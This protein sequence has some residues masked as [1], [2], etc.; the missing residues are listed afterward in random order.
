MAIYT[1][2]GSSSHY[3]PHKRKL[4]QKI[5]PGCPKREMANERPTYRKQGR[6]QNKTW[7]LSL[8]SSTWQLVHTNIHESTW[9]VEDLSLSGLCNRGTD[10]RKHQHTPG[11]LLTLH[12][13]VHPARSK[14]S[15]S[16]GATPPIEA[17]HLKRLFCHQGLT[18]KEDGVQHLCSHSLLP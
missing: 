5:C 6:R 9:P 15:P 10:G 16:V 2:T 8:G 18:P 13:L 1:K 7:P 11:G 12:I 17:V 4:P 3:K 14:I